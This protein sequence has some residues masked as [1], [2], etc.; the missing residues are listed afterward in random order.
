MTLKEFKKSKNQKQ[1]SVLDKFKTEILDLHNDNYSLV[2]IQEFLKDNG[3]KTTF[4]NLSKYIKKI[5]NSTDN[6]KELPKTKK[7]EVKKTET[8]KEIK[9]EPLFPK[10]QR[11]GKD[12]EIKDAPDWAQ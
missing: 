8:T 9:A 11:V 2:S 5:K 10:L 3:V 1:I 7:E 6:S 12:S 4:Q